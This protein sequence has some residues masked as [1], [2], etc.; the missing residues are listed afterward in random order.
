M[1]KGS[2]LPK[3][4]EPLSGEAS[5]LRGWAPTAVYFL[6]PGPWPQSVLGGGAHLLRGLAPLIRI[7]SAIKLTSWMALNKYQI[8]IRYKITSEESVVLG[9]KGSRVLIR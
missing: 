2:N 6:T 7:D 3:L 1:E 8:Q 5:S 9:S 4:R